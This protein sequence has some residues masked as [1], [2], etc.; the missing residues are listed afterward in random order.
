MRVVEESA[1]GFG[2]VADGRPSLKVGQTVSLAIGSSCCE[3]RIAHL[4]H[5]GELTKIGLERIRELARRESGG[6]LAFLREM[7]AGKRGTVLRLAVIVALCMIFFTWGLSLEKDSAGGQFAWLPGNWESNGN[8]SQPTRTYSPDHGEQTVALSFLRL[9]ALKTP[10]LAQGL[11]LTDDQK[12]SVSGIIRDTT[13]ALQYLYSTRDSESP[14]V[15]SETGL[16]V[17][18]EAWLQIDSVLTDEQRVRWE[19]IVRD[20]NQVAHPDGDALSK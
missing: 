13:S 20:E 2:I 16:R 1:G 5:D 7:L 18:R 17:L 6:I 8:S 15:W 4:S 9:D 3:V 14:E 19:S 12:K 10:S 11:H